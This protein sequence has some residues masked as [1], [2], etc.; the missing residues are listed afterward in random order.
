MTKPDQHCSAESCDAVAMLWKLIKFYDQIDRDHADGE[1][2]L[3]DEA[4]AVVAA[5]QSPDVAQAAVV[6]EVDRLRS[7][8][9]S[10]VHGAEVVDL[11]NGEFIGLHLP[12][13]SL[14]SQPSPAA[15]VERK[16]DWCEIGNDGWLTLKHSSAV[17]ERAEVSIVPMALSDGRTDYFVQ[18]KVG[19]RAVTP[20]VFREEYKSA[21][22]VALYDWLL[23]G[24][25]EEPDCV[26]FGPDDW[27]GRVMPAVPQGVVKS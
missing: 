10:C 15:T 7:I 21:Y 5:A 17:S 6:I 2:K 22:H 26:E 13:K 23:N 8:I 25:G 14:A 18:I 4:A 27:P 19:D 24:T 9:R 1:A 20:H 11:G 3:L 16:A 12:N